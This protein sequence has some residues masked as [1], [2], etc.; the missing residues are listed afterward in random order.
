[1]KIILLAL[2]SVFTTFLMANGAEE[3]GGNLRIFPK[4]HNTFFVVNA[5]KKVDDAVI[6]RLVSATL[7]QFNIDIRYIKG[8]APQVENAG[9]KLKEL[10]ANGAMWI[11]DNP[12]YPITLG[13]CE[14]GWA[15][16]NVFPLAT[17][18]E[19]KK[20]ESRLLSAICRIFA[21]I[22][23][24]GDSMMMPACV[25][26]P[27]RGVK[28]LDNLVCHEYSPEAIGKVS[29]G[30]RAAGYKTANIGTYYDAC[31]G[32]WAPAPTNAVQ[33]KIW[34]EVH[35]LPTKP[36]VILPESQRRKR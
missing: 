26:R 20:T 28:G 1:M 32:G 33:K 21:N 23:N 4:D 19:V 3:L 15:Y 7:N 22:H 16:V 8:N 10:G 34:D 11:I 36:L 13:A 12:N 14:D 29:A 30:L 25:M 5:Q 31:E 35:Q 2:F 18:A 24:V 6:S 27:S 9:A 17:E